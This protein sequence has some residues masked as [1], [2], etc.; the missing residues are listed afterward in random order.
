MPNKSPTDSNKLRVTL[1]KFFYSFF[2]KKGIFLRNSKS[3]KSNI[4]KS[5]KFFIK[6]L[7]GIILLLP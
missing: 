3:V 4:I 1:E 7:Y 6:K 2:N 5:S